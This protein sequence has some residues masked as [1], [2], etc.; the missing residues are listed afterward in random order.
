MLFCSE[1]SYFYTNPKSP[2]SVAE[3]VS[4][5]DS[6][7]PHVGLQAFKTV[8]RAETSF[9]LAGTLLGLLGTIVRLPAPRL[10]FRL[11]RTSTS[12]PSHAIIVHKVIDC[13]VLCLYLM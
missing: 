13:Y 3:S 1:T 8:L 9:H 11:R 4:L 12:C 7:V 6:I 2:G 10:E 5:L